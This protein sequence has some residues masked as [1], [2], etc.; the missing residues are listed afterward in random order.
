MAATLVPTGTLLG[1][2]RKNQLN[3]LTPLYAT[4]DF[5]RRGKLPDPFHNLPTWSRNVPLVVLANNTT[6]NGAE[7]IAA[8]LQDS[9]RAVVIGEHTAG[10]AAVN[11]RFNDVS[12]NALILTTGYLYRQGGQSI[13][14]VGV[15]PNVELAAPKEQGARSAWGKMRSYRLRSTLLSS[16]ARVPS[17]T[18]SRRMHDSNESASTSGSLLMR[19]HAADHPLPCSSPANRLAAL[20]TAMIDAVVM[21]S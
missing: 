3:A 1:E 7:F 21:F 20:S 2:V 15:T 12:G 14:G 13:E 11:S 19:K 6:A 4:A 9:Q 10:R 8:A 16:G 5:Y 17:D 18:A